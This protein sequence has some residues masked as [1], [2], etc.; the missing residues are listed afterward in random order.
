MKDLLWTLAFLG[1][2]AG[3]LRL[4]HGLGATTNLSDAVP[5]GLWKIMNM[6]AGVALSTGGFTIG[7]LVY[8]LRQERF[9]PLV[10]P[11]VLVAFLG[12]GSSCLALLFDIGLPQ[13]FWHPFIMWNEHSFL[14]E[15]FWCVML[16]FTVT[17]IELLPTV[18]EK[19]GATRLTR[20]LHGIAF[21]VVVFGIS[22]STLH[23]SS[24]GS[25][26]LVTPQ[27]LHGLW[28]SPLLPLFFI[29]SA[30]GAGMMFLLWACILHARWYDPEALWGSRPSAD[31]GVCSLASGDA[32]NVPRGVGRDAPMLRNLAGIAA[33]ILALYLTLKLYDLGRT[34]AWRLL[35]SGAWESWL[36]GCELILTAVLPVTLVAI[37][38]SRHSPTCLG[39]AAFT[40]TA[41]LVLNRLN[42]GIFGYWRDAQTIYVPSLVEW[43]LGLGVIA[44]AALAFLAAVENLA[45]F[46]PAIRPRPR[47][48]RPRF[49]AFTHV[50]TGAL[51]SDLHRVTMIAAVVVPL[52]WVM[53]YPPYRR[54]AQQ[55]ISPPS[56]LDA[57]RAVLRIDGDRAGVHAEFAHAAHQQRLG[58]AES[59]NIC[60]H[61]ALPGD[62]STPCSRCHRDLLCESRIFD[63]AEHM[64][65]VASAET[66]KGMQPR[67]RSCGICHERGR[68]KSAANAK[69]CLDCHRQNMMLVGAPAQAGDLGNASSYM[70]AM[71]G[72]CLL[73]HRREAVNRAQPHLPECATC[74]PTLRPR[75]PAADREAHKAGAGVD[76]SPGAATRRK[77]LLGSVLSSR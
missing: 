40:A 8:V 57:T 14:F 58:A 74:H 63:H 37:R 3:L 72:T 45:I 76:D 44:G 10:R 36:Y 28:Y 21:G 41:G 25:L 38:R 31:I 26:F 6:V 62:R 73:C 77:F 27:R 13:R 55:A 7:F 39:V 75:S 5:W 11:A 60:H 9:R 64:R 51:T 34:G 16:Y 1:L 24:L 33:G 47:R 66:L 35:L 12:Y 52:G 32:A 2:V 65:S 69:S 20:W 59:C 43:A 61:I 49:D 17:A 68:A 50:W 70:E 30:M 67:N 29:I 48:F 71:H 53:M 56:A 15:V 23:H 54:P 42:V 18:L 46:T 19:A 4:T 22:L